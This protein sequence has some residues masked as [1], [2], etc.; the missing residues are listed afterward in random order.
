MLD[1]LSFTEGT[2]SHYGK[3][4]NGTVLSSPN[5]PDLVG[6]KNVSVTDLSKHPNILVQ[7]NSSIKSTAAGRYQFLKGTWDG[8]GMSDFSAA[9]QDVAAVKLMK[10]RGMIQPLLE[11][12][13][14]KAVHKG[15]P[16]WASLPKEGGGSYYGGQTARSLEQIEAK[17][18]EAL[19]QRGG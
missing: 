10:R 14:A 11:G 18:K 9:S 3:V 15:A 4:V 1:V 2:G 19:K 6:K 5:F 16:E 12:D 7:V 8:L 17:Y 13:V